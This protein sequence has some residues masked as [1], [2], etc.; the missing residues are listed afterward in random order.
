MQT[1]IGFIARPLGY[2]LGWLYDIVGSYGLAIVIFTIVVKVCLYPLY[3]KQMKSTVG[4]SKLQPKLKALQQK[5][6]NDKDTLNQKMAELYRQEGI[7]PAGGCLPMLIQMPI[8]FGLF[9]LLRNPLAYMGT[10]ERMLFAIHESFLWMTDLSQPDKWILPILAGIA[11]FFAFSMQQQQQQ[12]MP[13]GQGGMM[14]SMKYIFPVMIVMLGRTFP[15]GLT[16]YWALGQVIQIF[17]NMRMNKVRKQMME[18]SGNQ[19]GRRRK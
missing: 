18:E 2:F 6:A 4:M 15:A 10:S 3:A 8:I 7:N 9:A 17:Y 16:I 11:T 14:K 12:D 13:G 19:G 1:V 5:Y